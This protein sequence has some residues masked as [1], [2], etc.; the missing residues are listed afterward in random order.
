MLVLSR[1]SSEE[2]LFPDLGMS[3]KVLDVGKRLVKLGIAAPASISV[4]RAEVARRCDQQADDIQPSE[5]HRLRNLVNALSLR[6]HVIQ[7]HLDLGDFAQAATVW[8]SLL[9]AL[10]T[11]EGDMVEGSLETAA[12]RS[13]DLRIL[14][15]DDNA[16]ERQLLAG[17][18]RLN[19]LHADT[20]SDGDEALAHLSSKPLPHCM[21]LDINMPRVDGNRVIR[22]VRSDDRYQD[23]R[24]F[25]VTGEGPQTNDDMPEGLRG[26]DGWF[27]KPLEPGELLKAISEIEFFDSVLGSSFSS[28]NMQPKSNYESFCDIC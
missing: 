19:G 1:R 20:V 27:Q 8:E 21:L 17:L 13:E 26:F 2:L 5:R 11:A 15:V 9:S 14:I 28:V 6:I 10:H 16:N 22:S 24:V 25:G 12:L 18:L 3:I 4:L 23:I 7:K